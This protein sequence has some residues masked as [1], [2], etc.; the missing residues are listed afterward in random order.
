VSLPPTTT[1]ST[2]VLSMPQRQALVPQRQYYFCDLKERV[3]YQHY[4]LHKTTHAI[5][6]DLD[7]PLQVVQCALQTFHEVG[8]VCREP[9]RMERAPLMSQ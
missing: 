1:R 8:Q 9:E 6:N 2:P 3:I 7:M 5:A 4:H